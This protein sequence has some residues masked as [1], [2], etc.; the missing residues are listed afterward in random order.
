MGCDDVKR[1]IYFFLDG[2]LGE[3]KV[4]D[5]LKHFDLCPDCD[6]RRRIQERLR[7]FV[8]RRIDRVPASERFKVRLTRSLRG[9][10]DNV[11]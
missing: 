9:L 3:K 2:S 5:V 4:Q 7:E 6:R 8:R 10:N 11:S 1:V